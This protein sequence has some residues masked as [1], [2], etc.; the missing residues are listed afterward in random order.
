M[1]I[2]NPV[3]W[4]AAKVTTSGH[5]LRLI[6]HA[7][8]HPDIDYAQAQPQVRRISFVDLRAALVEGFDD[9]G[10]FRD[11]VIFLCLIYPVIGLVLAWAV[12]GSHALELVFPIFAGF[13]LIGPFAA[14][15]L[16]EMSRRRENG[17]SVDWTHGFSA[18]ASQSA[19]KI[20]ELGLVLVAL[21]ALWLVAAWAI[22]AAT[23][24]PAVP[25]SPAA[26]ASA[27]FTTHAGWALIGLGC[28]TG[29]V[30]AIIAFSISVVSFPLLLD[31]KATIATAISVSLRVIKE[32][33]GPMLAWG[34]IVAGSLVLGIMTALVGLIV[35]LPVLGHATWRLYRKVI[36]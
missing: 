26:F 25:L 33:P 28:A 21:Y 4:G 31:R 5:A 1:W 6:G 10:H 2:R 13:A 35:V 27:V 17:E 15:W 16:Y 24:G 7:L 11:D 14:L 34:L 22:Y 32:N 12:S 8:V 3:E 9:F 36:V 19:A 23:L 20:F 18:F 30:F 29:L